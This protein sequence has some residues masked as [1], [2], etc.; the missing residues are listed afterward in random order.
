M[1][2]TY[3]LLLLLIFA[4]L[5]GYS[6]YGNSP[7]QIENLPEEEI[8]VHTDKDIYFAGDMVFFKLYLRSGNARSHA[9]SSRVAYLSVNGKDGQPIARHEVLLNSQTAYGGIML[10]DTLSTALLTLSAW[11]SK[12]LIDDTPP[13]RKQI[14][15][16]NRFDAGMA[17]FISENRP[18]KE[19]LAPPSVQGLRTEFIPSVNGTFAVLLYTGKGCLPYIRLE[20]E[21]KNI[22]ITPERTGL[23]TSC[24]EIIIARGGRV[25][26]RENVSSTDTTVSYSI[27]PGDLGYGHLSLELKGQNN[28]N[29]FEACWYNMIPATPVIDIFTDKEAY[30]QR[31]RVLLN[32]RK[33]E[34]MTRVASA[35]ISVVKTESLLHN[36]PDIR[37]VLQRA[38]EG[39]GDNMPC[40]RFMLTA[41]GFIPAELTKVASER[42]P[43]LQPEILIV[44]ELREPVISGRVTTAG[45]NE[46]VSGATIFLSAADSIA[47]L[48]YSKTRQDGSFYFQMNEYYRQK[49]S[50][51]NLFI[52]GE[53]AG[54]YRITV[55]DKFAPLPFNPL[56]IVPH[57]NIGNYLEEAAMIRR[58]MQAYDIR[59][60]HNTP[61]I[62]GY[63]HYSVPFL[64]RVPTHRINT[65]D[66]IPL[67][68]MTEIANEIVPDLRVRGRGNDISPVVICSR[69]RSYMPGLPV[70]FMNGV[71]VR[72][73][74][75]IAGLSSDDLAVVEILSVPWSFGSIRFNGIVSLFDGKGTEKLPADRLRTEL[76]TI[77]QLERVTFRNI[78]YNSRERNDPGIPDM[79]ETLFWEPSALVDEGTPEDVIFYTGDLKGS[80]TIII[81]GVTTEGEPF[82]GRTKISVN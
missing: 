18:G 69:T 28:E 22:V 19:I 61:D 34:E 53:E 7:L 50:Y 80:Y 58:V 62:P 25:V 46:P 45:S 54:R 66:Y 4:K 36:G 47:N 27:E 6:Y 64:Y 68:N 23:D 9:H 41:E 77:P 43:E 21:N 56:S 82:S 48:Q 26:W 73:F 10:P 3:I 65:S 76:E 40:Y 57:E 32:F 16:V 55:R 11:T 14:V 37:Q 30:G 29:V 1:R 79:R 42:Y 5:P 33:Q 60:Y 2:Q 31:E 35:S 13:F 71:Y 17:G 51:V 20:K 24:R 67:D 12:M 44:P 15:A 75:D 49:A 38:T 8:H 74:A 59:T 72:N 81:E 52:P 70:F 78:K 63:V 39:C